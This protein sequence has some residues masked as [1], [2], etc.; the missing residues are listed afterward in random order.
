MSIKTIKNIEDLNYIFNTNEHT[1]Q[2]VI[3][4]NILPLVEGVM[5][6]DHT[7]KTKYHPRQ[8]LA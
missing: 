2:Y 6:D 4:L 5:V 7:K 8:T 1:K 3:E